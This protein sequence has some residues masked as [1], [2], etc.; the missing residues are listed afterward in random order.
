[1][2]K[3]HSTAPAPE[4]GKACGYGCTP[5]VGWRWYAALA[6]WERVCHAHRGGP[7]VTKAGHYVPDAAAGR[8]AQQPVSPPQEPPPPAEHDG[9]FEH[10]GRL[11]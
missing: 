6:G 2:S 7:S 10:D 8:T 11:S 1:M 3:F 4:P 9:L 5:S